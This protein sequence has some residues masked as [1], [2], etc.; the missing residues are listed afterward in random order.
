MLATQPQEVLSTYIQG[1]QATVWFLHVL[2]RHKTSVNTFEMS[3]S[4]IDIDGTTE[5]GRRSGLQVIRK[6]SRFF[7]R[8]LVEFKNLESIEESGF[9]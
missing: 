9:R 3:I 2:G 1:D 5:S 8:Q 7:D 4:S 6:I